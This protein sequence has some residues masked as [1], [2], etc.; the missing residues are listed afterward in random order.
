M[1][2]A[3][4]VHLPDTIGAVTAQPPLGQPARAPE[5][6][7][8]P[9][10]RV[11]LDLGNVW[12]VALTLVGV[13][14]LVSLGLLVLRRGSGVL[15][16][17]VIAWFASIAMEPAVSRLSRRM[18][19]GV[20]TGI[21]MVGLVLLGAGF[22]LAFGRLFLDQLA[23]ILRGMPA[24]VQALIEWANARLHTDY[25]V[26]DVLASL[27]L[28]PAQVAR[29]AG[30]L[31]GGVLG[32]LGSLAG[33][34][35]GLLA[36]TLLTFYLSADA[37]RLRH[38]VVTLFPARAQ[39]VV[40]TIWDVTATKTGGYVAGRSVL[41]AV[42]AVLSTVV[43]L[44]IGMPYWL[45]LGIWT[46]VV[47]QL[48]PT[49][50]TYISIALPV[51]VGLL[52]PRPWV[53]LAALAWSLIYQQVENLALEPRVNAR[54]VSVHPAVAFV[55]VV[56]GVSLFGPVG[57]LLAVP[58]VAMLLSLVGLYATRYELAG[59][60]GQVQAPVVLVIE[61]EPG[62]GAGRVGQWLRAS[63]VRLRV[64]RPYAGQTVP[65]RVDAD[66]LLVL[67]GSSGATEDEDAPWL[68]ATRALIRQAVADAVPTWGICLGAQLLA[69]ALGGEVARGEA[70][71]EI[72]VGVLRRT[73]EPDPVFGDLPVTS[74]AAQF[75]QDAVTRLPE[76]AVRLLE[77]EVYPVQAFRV[78]ECAWGVQFHPEVGAE[79]M[80]AWARE[81]P[82][83]L[84]QAGRAEAE[85]VE[86]MVCAQDELDATW[87][88]AARRWA[89][90][91][92]ARAGGPPQ[93]ASGGAAG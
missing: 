1:N 67:G 4:P 87:E 32:V 35:F 46:G 89:E 22:L 75:H 30:E 61:H 38:W 36:F 81:V 25:N 83:M 71:P 21:V 40:Q 70:G 55:S 60:P 37:P 14:A 90:Q 72:G 10:L 20:A 58:V 50:G 2:G 77:G 57:A 48:V 73:G 47:A 63:G 43:F 80:A 86:E 39:G 17:V 11:V 31:A 64:C 66:G 23:Q 76:G 13:A 27:E 3:R 78:G 44:V 69:V 93:P 49:I 5:D 79:Q 19:R 24:F 65:E 42:N 29:Y 88:P 15:S 34:V 53:G 84:A 33:A 26:N 45:A 68:P 41:A 82:E 92:R 12:R 62:A 7:A 8:E 9:P 74:R 52:S 16:T 51:L 18:R 91:V 56:L 59:E 54:A 28:T 85:L 6:G